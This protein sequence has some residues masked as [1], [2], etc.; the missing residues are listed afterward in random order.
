MDLAAASILNAGRAAFVQKDPLRMRVRD[1]FDVATPQSGAEKGIRGRATQS[2]APGDGIGAD[3]LGVRA[4]EIVATRQA[5]FRGGRVEMALERM[6]FA[7]DRGDCKRTVAPDL[8]GRADPPFEAIEDRL[9]VAPSPTGIAGIAPVVEVMRQA[10]AINESID[11]AGSADDLAA[12]P[13][14]GAPIEPIVGIGAILPIDAL[15][16]E[17][18]PIADWRPDPEP[19]V[20]AAGF[21]NQNAVAA[22]FRQAVRQHAACRSRSDDDEIE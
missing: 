21:E 4:V 3:T 9:D 2:I 17:G 6:G 19:P 16:E 8:A 14:G 5:Q 1:E 20:V 11:R 15:V 7:L 18:L 12:R 13:I 22:P 10:A